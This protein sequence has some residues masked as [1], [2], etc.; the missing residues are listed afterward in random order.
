M[1]FL[2][3][4]WG[5]INILNQI[6][7]QIKLKKNIFVPNLEDTLNLNICFPGHLLQTIL[8]YIKGTT[9]IYQNIG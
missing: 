4:K 3:C 7:R 1:E 9:V 6:R 2:Y 8:T 5:V